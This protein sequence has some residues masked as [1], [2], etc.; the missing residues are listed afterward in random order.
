MRGACLHFI[1]SYSLRHVRNVMALTDGTDP[2]TL[3]HS[4]LVSVI[5]PT[6]HRP[7]LLL[8]AIR[9]VL[10]QTVRD[11][12]VIVVID[13]HDP[14]TAE[15]VCSEE[16]VRIRVVNN[17]SSL[18]AGRSRNRG[19][20][21]ASG[22]FVAFLDDDDEWL[23]NKLEKQVKQAA[24]RDDVLVTCISRV[25]TPEGTYAWP[26]T[27]YDNAR[28]FDE[29]L[30]V[31]QGPFSG[32]SFIQTSSQFLSRSL[33]LRSPFPESSPHD[34]WEFVMRLAL[35]M[36]AR[37]ETVPDVLVIHYMGS[38]GASLSNKDAWKASL[39]WLISMRP[40]MTRGAYSGFCLGVVAPRAAKEKDYTAILP[41][42]WQ[43]LRH[44]APNAVLLSFFVAVWLIPEHARRRVRLAITQGLKAYKVK[45]SPLSA[46]CLATHVPLDVSSGSR[47]NY[48]DSRP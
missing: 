7:G 20:A 48:Q 13:G 15:A 28:P 16:D 3:P 40:I 19:V 9:S 44:G 41:L 39:N 18:G 38:Q 17:P 34:D 26:T 42:L 22:R 1:R 10:S 37:I 24:G 31:K 36:R 14:S 25:V 33:Y 47:D 8:R 11:L 43:A 46:T 27:I 32:A 35:Q 29:Y 6:I 5:I 23:P 45:S 4:P 21:C 2:V 30:F 12:E